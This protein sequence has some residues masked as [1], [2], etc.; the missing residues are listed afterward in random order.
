[1][2]KYPALLCLL[3]LSITVKSQTTSS[4]NKQ[5]QQTCLQMV[6]Y[7]LQTANEAV[8]NPN[9]RPERAAKRKKLVEK[10]KSQLEDG[11]PPCDIYSEIYKASN[12][13]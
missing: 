12:T 5:D 11:T 9:S 4:S 13:F 10:W 2:L 3:L 6:N 7:M 1:M 8:Y